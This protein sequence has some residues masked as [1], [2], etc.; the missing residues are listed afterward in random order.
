MAAQ[1]GVART[2]VAYTPYTR[3]RFAPRDRSMPPAVVEEDVPYTVPEGS[4]L[5][6][7]QLHP[8]TGEIIGKAYIPL[9]K[10]IGANETI[11]VCGASGSGKT[12]LMRVLAEHYAIDKG[13]CVIIIDISKNQYWSFGYQ[14]DREDMLMG[15]DEAG[16]VPTAIPEVEV[17]VPIYDEPV[18]GF[19]VMQR[20]QHATKLL[21]LKTAGLTPAGFF[22]LGDIDPSGR[23]YQNFLELILNVP[24][25]RK[26]VDFIRSELHKLMQDPSKARSVASLVNLFEPLTEQG[27]IRDNGTDVREMLHSPRVGRPGK[28]SV[29]S[30]ATSET[31]DRRKKALITTILQQLFDI[32]KDDLSLKPVLIIDE[33]KE[34]APKKPSDSP[35]TFGMLSR[36]HLQCRAWGVTRI[37]GFQNEKD[38]ADYLLGANTPIQVNLTKSLLLRDGFTRLNGTGY[39]QVFV[40][41]TGD[42]AVPDMNFFAHCYPC[43]TKHVD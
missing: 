10:K 1:I 21:S 26:T 22:E 9:S 38:V 36:I 25:H 30:L 20:D 2:K 41:G 14:Q 23:V 8:D 19:N 7:N 6:G 34:V 32:V 16:W 4:I 40:E 27:I 24:K 13:R 37:Y 15:L 5:F 42:K 11:N 39:A 18:L 28:I 17:Y 43:R 35:A 12:V 33:T 29:I 31:N 3:S